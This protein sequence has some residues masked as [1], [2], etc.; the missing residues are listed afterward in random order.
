[1]NKKISPARTIA[2]NKKARFNYTIEDELEAG[3]ILM[4][5]E[6][7]SIRA[8]KVNINDAYADK[9]DGELYLLNSHI[10]EF[11]GANRFNHNPTRPRKLLLHKKEVDKLLGKVKEKGV[12]LIP[13]SLYINDKNIAK[14]KLGVAK[15]KKLY[16]KRATMKERD[17][18]R[19]KERI[20]KGINN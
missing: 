18:Q 11:E 16:D 4:G 6:I 7:K 15:G 2:M 8:G 5:S 17:W 13:L 12:T 9:K 1:M 20:M 10:A 14:I 3:I 19:D